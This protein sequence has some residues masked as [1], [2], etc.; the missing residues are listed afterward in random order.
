M[1]EFTRG[2]TVESVHHGAVAVANARGELVAW[3]GDPRAITFMR[4]SAKPLQALP[5]LEHGGQRK[6]GLTQREVA[7]MCA[8]HSGTD[9]HVAVL[10]S[11]QSKAGIS[12]NALLCGV[13][14]PLDEATTEAMRERNEQPTPN[15]HNCSGKHSGMLA[16]SKLQADDRQD[17][18]PS[19]DYISPQH[20]I[21]HEI[22]QAVAAM[23]Q[24]NVKDI[25]MGIDGCSAPNFAMP[26]FHAAV[27]YARLCDPLEGQVSPPELAE[28]CR[29][30]TAAMMAN[31][32][33]V[34]GPRRFD[35]RLMEVTVGRIVSKGGAEGYQGIGLL[36][37]ALG[38][39]SPALGIALKIADGD[40]RG[41][42]RSAASMEVLR[43]LGILSDEEIDALAEFGPTIPIHN[44][45]KILVGRAAPIFELVY[46]SERTGV[47][48]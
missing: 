11:I 21:Q 9:E 3:F 48:S 37:G 22:L 31:P 26:L 41:K 23:C 36:P 1:L 33:M 19:L 20:P 34:G 8:S 18:P 29:T 6:F 32:D 10:R 28:A 25:Q 17:E 44:W 24:I 5:F 46:E 42:A 14:L 15:R 43:Q 39:G 45:R 40:Q 38:R 2:Q 16:F 27:G 30:V 47:D 7:I 4:S 12:E 35:T 13:H